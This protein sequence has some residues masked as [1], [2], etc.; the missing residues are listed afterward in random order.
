MAARNLAL[1]ASKTSG[2]NRE[3][4]TGPG[5]VHEGAAQLSEAAVIERAKHNAER[6][7]HDVDVLEVKLSPGV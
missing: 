2:L 3:R 4:S 6:L 1:G 7:G 5:Q